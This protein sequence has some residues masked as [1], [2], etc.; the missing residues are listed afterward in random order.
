MAGPR[1][2]PPAG[3][4]T[5]PETASP[6][7]M[8][9]SGSRPALPAVP[10]SDPA[11]VAALAATAALV[12]LSVTF[13]IFDTDFWQHL[14][15]GRTIWETRSAPTAQLW[16]W[17]TY[18]TTDVNASWGFRALVWPFWSLGGVWGLFAWRWLTTLA[19][20]GILVALGR[21][22]G[23]R[24]FAPLAVVL[25]CALLYRIRSQIRPETL[26]AVLLAAQLWVLETRRQGGRD[27]SVWCIPIA[28]AWANAHISWYLGFVVT[29]AY[30]LDDLLRGRGGD[31]AA[32]ARARRLAI[33]TLGALVMSFVNPWG[34]RALWQPF[35]YFLYW[36]HEPIFTIIREL[37]P[38]DWKDYGRSPL[39]VL[40]AA[41]PALILWQAR[42]RRFDRVEAILCVGLTAL[43]LSTQRFTGAYSLVAMPFLMRA[44]ARWVDARRWPG[45]TTI[46]AARA[47]MVGALCAGLAVS[48][49]RRVD[50]PVRI[51]IDYGSYPVRACDLIASAGVR[52]RGFNNFEYGGYQAWRFWPDRGRLPFIDVHQAGTTLDRQLYVSALRSAAG[53]QALDARHRFDY[54]LL[55]RDPAIAFRLPDVLDAD[56]SWGLAFIDDAATLH[57]RRG[58]RFA[59][60]AERLA[61]H[62]LPA[63]NERVAALGVAVAGDST[64]RS[65]VA[66]ELRR[67]VDGS[68]W[69]AEALSLLA[70]IALSEGRYAE[71]RALLERGLGISPG[72]GRAH[73]R[74]GRI[75]LEEGRARDALR[76]FERERA[77][78]PDVPDLAFLTGR[79]WRLLGEP[80]RAREWYQRELRRD[81]GH[82][83]ARDSLA[84]LDRRLP[85]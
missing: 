75:D 29:G 26:V 67:V 9:G 55:A 13:Q 62:H 54:V 81:P 68:P 49:S 10:L 64:L 34:W 1:K 53:W 44:T 45:W 73:E 21:R 31:A 77:L 61:Y 79:A 74:L 25:M 33:T 12:L 69:H 50:P 35:E 37:R 85:G 56:S 57:L 19:A 32:W 18:G 80:G 16:T 66:A 2:R 14:L 23:A 8:P 59:A 42:H 6:R 11:M 20:L 17:P 36:R 48:E 51:A 78:R 22:M 30:L 28:W 63:G 15:V 41:W 65:A 39:P 72:L 76:Q 71:A 40:V 3:Q 82:S 4:R 58:G 24:G 5:H 27:R 52:G 47:A 43:A 70:N 7:A 38:V 60:L 46:P 84:A 83:E